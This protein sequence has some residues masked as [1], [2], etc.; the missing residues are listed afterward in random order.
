MRSVMGPVG[1]DLGGFE[2][3]NKFY[4][5]TKVDSQH[6]LVKQDAEVSMLSHKPITDFLQLWLLRS[7]C[8]VGGN[9]K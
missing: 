1:H 5:I 9:I 3:N 6:A 7:T 8:S 4:E 2:F